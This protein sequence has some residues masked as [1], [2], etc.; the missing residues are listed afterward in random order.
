MSR[1]VRFCKSSVEMGVHPGKSPW[2]PTKTGG[3]V[4][5][6][7]FLF[8]IG[9]VFL[10]LPAFNFS[11]VHFL[12]GS[13]WGSKHEGAGN[14]GQYIC[15]D[16]KEFIRKDHP[17]QIASRKTYSASSSKRVLCGNP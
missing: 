5:M 3:L 15:R 17:W 7:V 10:K 6:M 2:N 12:T 4:Q 1:V 9:M 13:K 14:R 16:T 11:G 8:S